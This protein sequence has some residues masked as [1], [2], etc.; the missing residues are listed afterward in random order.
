[1]DMI[2][3]II[4]E[5][6]RCYSMHIQRNSLASNINKLF[7]NRITQIYGYSLHCTKKAL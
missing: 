7:F 6:Y 1:M 4:I 3:M 5:G 2:S